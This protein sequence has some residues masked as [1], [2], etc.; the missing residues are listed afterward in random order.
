MQHEASVCNRSELGETLG[1]P[2]QSSL[3]SDQ[4]WRTQKL[5][6][7]DTVVT[8]CVLRHGFTSLVAD[9][10]YSEPT[11]AVLVGHKGQT[12]TSRYIHSA[13]AALAA[14][15]DTVAIAAP[16]RMGDIRPSPEVVLRVGP[17][18]S[19]LFRTSGCPDEPGRHAR[20][21]RPDDRLRR[22]GK[23]PFMTGK[24]VKVNGGK[25]V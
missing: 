9:L 24:I 13:D 20:R 3:S 11:I 16:A 19:R 10:G 23:V 7:V 15:A 4:A 2:A 12:M 1:L 14:A 25:T 5:P 6:T 18:I 22:L 8:L 17:E 21:T